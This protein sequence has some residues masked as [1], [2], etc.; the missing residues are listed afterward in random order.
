MNDAE[1]GDIGTIDAVSDCS[2]TLEGKRSQ[3][4]RNIET[5]GSA[6]GEVGQ[7]VAG[8]LHAGDIAIGCIQ[9]A[10]FNYPETDL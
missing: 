5:R 9:I 2:A 6:I 1:N 4:R 10:A 7:A 8:G 3:S